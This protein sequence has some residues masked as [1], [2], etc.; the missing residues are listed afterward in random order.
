MA[1]VCPAGYTTFREKNLYNLVRSSQKLPNK[2]FL[3][4]DS[5]SEGHGSQRG[6]LWTFVTPF[7]H[8]MVREINTANP[9]AWN[10]NIIFDLDAR[11][12]YLIRLFETQEPAALILEAMCHPNVL[13]AATHIEAFWSQSCGEWFLSSP[14]SSS[15]V[16][17][18]HSSS[19]SSS[20]RMSALM[21]AAALQ[22][23]IIV[24]RDHPDLLDE[25]RNDSKELQSISCVK[26]YIGIDTFFQSTLSRIVEACLFSPYFSRSVSAAVA[27]VRDDDSKSASTTNSSSKKVIGAAHVS[28]QVSAI[29]KKL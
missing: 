26:V 27:V 9:V 16:A 20:V 4:E 25:V 10:G 1:A 28:A 3:I 11:A 8:A 17:A 13:S 21:C 6:L 18:V 2:G 29:E 15:S 14:P 24:F 5:L 7:Q 19:S 12:Q 23:L 22:S